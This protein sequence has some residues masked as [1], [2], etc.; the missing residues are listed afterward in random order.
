VTDKFLDVQLNHIGNIP[1]DESLRQSVCRQR[2]VCDFLP[3]SRSAQAFF[4]L[5]HRVEGWKLKNHSNGSLNFFLE[6][7]I[8]A[9]VS[10]E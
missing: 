6:K 2:A 8:Q 4:S 3:N 9:G 1:F 5:A 10:S 7:M